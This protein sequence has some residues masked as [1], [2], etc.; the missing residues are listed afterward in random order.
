M[1]EF[2]GAPLLEPFED[3]VE[4]KLRAPP[5]LPGTATTTFRI[6]AIPPRP[7]GLGNVIRSA[8]LAISPSAIRACGVRLHAGSN[9][10]DS[11]RHLP[12]HLSPY[13]SESRELPF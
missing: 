11:A 2:I 4:A 10:G 1:P 9:L 3:G 6:S 12:D 8:G 13:E 5:E 7:A